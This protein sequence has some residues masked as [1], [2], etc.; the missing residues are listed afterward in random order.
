MTRKVSEDFT[1]LKSFIEQYSLTETVADRQF[2]NLLKGFHKNYYSY[3][4]LIL[5]L[6]HKQSWMHEEQLHRFKESCS[7]I[8]QA[9]FLMCHGTYKAANLL[10]RSSIENFVKGLGYQVDPNIL[11]E[12]SVYKVFE[13]ARDFK[14]CKSPNF[15]SLFDQ[16]HAEY[17]NLCKFTHTATFQEMEQVTALNSL[18]NF[19]FQKASSLVSTI[20]RILNNYLLILIWTYRDVFFSLHVDTRDNILMPISSKNR[21]AIFSGLE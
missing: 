12:G 2:L 14:E 13:I 1:L 4:S 21:L 20:K 5:H 8:G 17:G 18:L 15:I 7:D 3:L 11:H 6:E 10:A 9:L 19:D 16:L